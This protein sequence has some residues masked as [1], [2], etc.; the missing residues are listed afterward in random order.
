MTIMS[1]PIFVAFCQEMASY[2]W[3]KVHNDKSLY[4]GYHLKSSVYTLKDTV[5]EVKRSPYDKNI[6]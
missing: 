2:I 4:I 1:N 5:N 3:Y 6:C